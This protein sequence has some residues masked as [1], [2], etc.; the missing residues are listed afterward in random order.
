M[1]L[2]VKRA[3]SGKEYEDLDIKVTLGTKE[4]LGISQEEKEPEKEE[5][6]EEIPEQG[7]NGFGF[8]FGF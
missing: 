4:S 1:T 6:P 2:Q 8:H 3:T 5:Q 7:Q